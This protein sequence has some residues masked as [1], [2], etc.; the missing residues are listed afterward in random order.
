MTGIYQVSCFFPTAVFAF[1]EIVLNGR[2][3]IWH[4]FV[5]LIPDTTTFLY[6][7]LTSVQTSVDLA[8]LGSGGVGRGNDRGMSEYTVDALVFS[9]RF[10]NCQPAHLFYGCS[11]RPLVYHSIGL[12]R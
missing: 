12:T 6:L 4:F 8:V 11:T 3:F 2:P 7:E 9:K 5:L 1:T 10:I